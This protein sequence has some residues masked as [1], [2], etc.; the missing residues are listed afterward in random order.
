MLKKLILALAA[1][2]VLVLILAWSAG[3]FHKKVE[4]GA[5]QAERRTLGSLPTDVV[6]K[7]TATEWVNVV[8]T[9]R[10]KRRT[11][12]S[13]KI[14][15]AIQEINVQA[16]DSVAE[17]QVLVRL[18]DRDLK[19][20]LEEAR[21]A[22]VAAE[23]NL[24]NL[25]K[26]L[27]RY[28]DLVGQGAVTQ[29]EYDGIQSRHTIAQADVSRGRESVKA[30]ETM[31]SYTV[32]KA[33]IRGKI[34]DKYAQAG[35][36]T[37]PGRPLLAIYDPTALR[38]E[39]AVP[40]ALAADLTIGSELDVKLETLN[41][42]VKGSIEEIVPQ[43]EAA[44]RSVLV[45]VQVPELPG[46]YEGMFGR[47]QIPSRERARYCAPKSAIRQVGQLAMAEVVHKDNTLERRMVKLGE[48][49]NY[50]R[51]EVLSGLEDGDR[52]VL[53]GPAP[54]PLPE[55]MAMPGLFGQ[56]EGGRP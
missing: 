23:A 2:A 18:D 51:V 16:G 15:A 27:K 46:V 50:G 24:Q 42:T 30:A 40:E 34:V 21:Q 25:E 55:G 17:G 29:Q 5:V 39:A 44:S 10:A 14:Q 11:E 12:V 7:I 4:P 36:L 45:K 38:L 6:H 3:A 47:L 52:V 48:H 56:G 28:K 37:S 22:V 33:P 32:I 19:A 35:D 41:R 20:R 13:A 26:D 54:P 8:G 43:A 1:I 9:L 49:S 31:L 53:Y